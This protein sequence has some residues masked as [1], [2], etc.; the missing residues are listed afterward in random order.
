MNN[1]ANVGRGDLKTS[2]ALKVVKADKASV[3]V[4]QP[5]PAQ[6]DKGSRF[7]SV[8]DSDSQVE[9]SQTKNAEV[10]KNVKSETAAPTDST[11]SSATETGLLQKEKKFNGRCRLFVGNLPNDLS[12]N[13]FQKFFEP[14]GELNEV[15]LNAPRG[16]GFLRLV[17][18]FLSVSAR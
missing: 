15:F 4:N 5:D 12:E 14:F 3:A 9:K 6:R 2:P 13:E 17:S 10:E 11:D 8:R 1:R 18:V 7:S 16:F